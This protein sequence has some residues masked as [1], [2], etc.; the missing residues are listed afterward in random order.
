MWHELQTYIVAGVAIQP[1]RDLRSSHRSAEIQ[2]Q[3]LV[4]ELPVVVIASGKQS[5]WM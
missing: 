4:G 5:D 2:V 1:Y 3:R